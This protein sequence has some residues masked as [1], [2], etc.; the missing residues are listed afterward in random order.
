M[1][2]QAWEGVVVYPRGE[3]KGGDLNGGG[4]E[5]VFCSRLNTVSVVFLPIVL[6]RSNKRPN[7]GECQRRPEGRRL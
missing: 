1:V 2:L 6:L 5:E 4:D 7:P 3:Q